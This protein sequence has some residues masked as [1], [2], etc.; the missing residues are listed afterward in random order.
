MASKEYPPGNQPGKSPEQT[1]VALDFNRIQK[2]AR[3]LRNFLKKLPADPG[4]G[5]VHDFRTQS[6]QLEANLQAF[7]L[8]SRRV[9]RRILQ[10]LSRLRK[11]AGKVR[12]MDVL[13]AFASRVPAEKGEQECSIRL[14]EYLGARRDKYAGKFH[15]ACRRDRPKLRRRLKKGKRK[16]AR[17]EARLN[18]NGPNRDPK[19]ADAPA[20][21]L[22]LA[23]ELSRT[24]RL[25]RANLHPFRLIVKELR[26]VLKL[27]D[28]PDQAMIHT[29]GEVKDSIGEWHDWEELV[30]IAAKAL[31]H[32]AQCSLI[33]QLKQTTQK[34]YETALAQ[35]ERLRKR[36]LGVGKKSRGTK[37]P[38]AAKPVLSAA[39]KLVA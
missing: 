2:P 9:G 17:L 23:S 3:K 11:R 33:R 38:V 26:N 10:P 5:D 34:K 30:G 36:Y 19:P 32:G 13:T 21:A 20:L 24:P 25:N 35:A 12:D 18:P 15:A 31:D 1:H 6:R 28:I 7:R 22:E 39:M 29:L 37:E 16:L 4:P 14:L 8:D 27:A